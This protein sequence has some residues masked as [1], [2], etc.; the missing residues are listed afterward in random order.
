[1]TLLLCAAALSACALVARLTDDAPSGPRTF[2]IDV[3][4]QAFDPASDPLAREL[5]LTTLTLRVVTAAGAFSEATAEAVVTA[6]DLDPT[7]PYTQMVPDIDGR[8]LRVE[9]EAT[10][11]GQ[12]VVDAISDKG[13]QEEYVGWTTFA[14]IGKVRLGF[15]FNSQS[16]AASAIELAVAPRGG[17]SPTVLVDSGVQ[18]SVIRTGQRDSPRSKSPSS[19]RSRNTRPGSRSTYTR[20][21]S[22]RI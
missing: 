12:T 6:G 13:G 20:R 1:M 19:S 7:Y 16:Y 14:A 18:G 21:L 8:L 15:S 11:A 3:H 9:A 17:Q 4:D 2:L 5:S 22:P 10:S